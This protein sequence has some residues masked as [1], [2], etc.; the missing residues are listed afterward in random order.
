MY[1]V[2]LLSVLLL[3]LARTLQPI[4]A[5]RS[6]QTRYGSFPLSRS[7]PN[8]RP[9]DKNDPGNTRR[10]PSS[11]VCT[12]SLLVCLGCFQ[13]L[14]LAPAHWNPRTGPDLHVVASSMSSSARSPFSF[15]SFNDCIGRSFVKPTGQPN[16]D[17]LVSKSVDYLNGLHRTIPWRWMEDWEGR[18]S[19][20]ILPKRLQKGFI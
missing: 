9:E 2:T 19:L 10:P 1:D 11:G 14:A 18:L 16:M 6:H 4:R 5:A 8:N 3:S 13:Q 17:P 20:T 7:S 15:R 12:F